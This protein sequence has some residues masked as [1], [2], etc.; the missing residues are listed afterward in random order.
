[1]YKYYNNV[2]GFNYRIAH[3]LPDREPESTFCIIKKN[4]PA[5][6]ETPRLSQW[7]Q[8][9]FIVGVK[10]AQ[11]KYDIYITALTPQITSKDNGLLRKAESQ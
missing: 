3:F 5:E 2:L 7:R 4:F 9:A 1:L 8:I 10:E 11:I 6:R